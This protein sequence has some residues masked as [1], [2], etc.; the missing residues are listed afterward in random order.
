MAWRSAATAEGDL[1][2]LVAL[3]LTADL[4]Y[5]NPFDLGDFG[6]VGA[7]AGLQIDA[8]DPEQPHPSGAA[9][10]LH[11]HGLDELWLCLELRVGDPHR[12]G[13]G[14]RGNERVGL[15][16]DPLGVQLAEVDIEVEPRFVGRDVAAGD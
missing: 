11:A 10:R 14:A 16:L 8:R 4:Q 7:A 13:G 12:L 3:A 9:R 15:T 6:D 5:A 2:A 1:D